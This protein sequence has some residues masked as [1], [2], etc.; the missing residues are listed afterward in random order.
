MDERVF[1]AKVGCPI[2][3][4]DAA[5][6]LP[7]TGYVGPEL[8]DSGT[9]F[10][11]NSTYMDVSD[12]PHMM[13]QWLAGG[14]VV[15]FLSMLVF[16][17][18]A[19]IVL[20]VHPPTHG[21]VV[22][23]VMV[24]LVLSAPIFFG[25]IAVR[26]GAGEFF[27]L[28]RRPIRFNRMTKKIYAIRQREH[29]GGHLAGDIFWEAPWND[30]SV[31]CVHKGPA[32]FQLDE[33]YHIRCYQ[34]DEEGKVMRAFAIGRE[35]QGTDG[36]CELLA[37]WNYWCAYMNSGPES[38]PEPLLYL[39]EYENVSESFLYCLYELGFNM[40]GVFRMI[41][42]PFVLFLTSH[43]LISMW[44]CRQPVWPD[45]VLDV[46]RV[47]MPDLYDKPSEETPVGWAATARA[48]QDGR[49]PQTPHCKTPMWTGDIDPMANARH[50]ERDRASA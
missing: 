40:P 25:W 14:T 5:H 43:R 1:R 17:Y 49:Y 4:W 33:H 41:F 15:A 18:A 10:R 12:Q 8:R 36:M 37:Q 7:I 22:D 32:K 16:L 50:W 44:T 45:E 35:W 19:T 47:E 9:I 34:L 13:R 30:R 6:R 24:V 20:I 2:P 42:S 31:F 23:I 48:R 27:S 11:I 39:S 26:F 21:D 46:S 3:E 28:T 38:L 29:H